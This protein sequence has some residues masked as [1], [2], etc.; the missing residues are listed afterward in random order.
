[1]ACVAIPL[2]GP[3]GP[4]ALTVDKLLLLGGDDAAEV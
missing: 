4:T 3:Y 1:M 2:S